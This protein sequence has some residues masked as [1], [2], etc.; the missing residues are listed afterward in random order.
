MMKFEAGKIILHEKSTP[1]KIEVWISFREEQRD[2]AQ[3][4]NLIVYLDYNRYTIPEIKAAAVEAAKLFLRRA[5][6]SEPAVSP[7]GR[8]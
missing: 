8:G 2:F 3:S 5:V 7:A 4:G 6:D 1:P